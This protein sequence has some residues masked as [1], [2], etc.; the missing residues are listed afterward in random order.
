MPANERTKMDLIEDDR[1][2]REAKKNEEY[3]SILVPI[4]S[5]IIAKTGNFENIWNMK[6]HMLLD[7]VRRIRK[8]Q[9][10][11]FLLQGAYS[12]F[13]SLKGIDKTRLDCFGDI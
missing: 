4:I 2:E 1:W 7:Y 9:D 11:E 8:I 13:A 6:I 12:G 3:K 5:T 10:A